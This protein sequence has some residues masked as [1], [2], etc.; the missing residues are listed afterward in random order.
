M[1]NVL[2]STTPSDHALVQNKTASPSRSELNSPTDDTSDFSEVFAGQVAPQLDK[3]TDLP[4]KGDVLPTEKITERTDDTRKGATAAQ[5]RL[6]LTLTAAEQTAQRLGSTENHQ[7]TVGHF[8]ITGDSDSDAT[9]PNR[10]RQIIAALPRTAAATDGPDRTMSSERTSD[11]LS[12]VKTAKAV[13]GQ[14]NLH[15]SYPFSQQ[16]HTRVTSHPTRTDRTLAGPGK[17]PLTAAKVAINQSSTFAK[18][19]SERRS[20]NPILAH[21]VAS[22]QHEQARLQSATMGADIMNRSDLT[23]PT[24]VFSSM[25]DISQAGAPLFATANIDRPLHAPQWGA[26]LGRQFVSLIRPGENGSHHAELRLD[27]PEL[28]P[29][30]VTININDSTVQAL[31]TSSHATVRNAVEQALPQLQQQLENEGLSL[32]QTSVG[33]DNSPS[34]FDADR[35]NQ[36]ALAS[37]HPGVEESSVSQA[38]TRRP[39]LVDALIDTFA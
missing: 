39:H 22:G 28:G 11:T 14:K 36:H 6:A 25:P 8:A 29:L 33:Q 13:L 34:H 2:M 1:N 18:A 16:Q 37:D 26:E 35:S 5:A 10:F 31:F 27:P 32:G 30:R 3:N 15:Q 19:D 38:T 17:G 24:A 9:L 21:N 23:A 4:S 7:Q 12:D 20:F